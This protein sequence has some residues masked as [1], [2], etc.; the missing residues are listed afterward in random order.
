MNI[1]VGFPLILSLFAAQAGNPGSA[2][3]PHDGG[4]VPSSTAV[5]PLFNDAA[6]LEF[7]LSTDFRLLKRERGQVSN[8]R[9][10]EILLEGE[11][12]AIGLQVRTRG[13]FRL[14]RTTCGDMPPIRLNFPTSAVEGTVFEGQDKLKLVTHCRNNEQYEQNTLQEY[15]AYRIYNLLTDKSFQ[16]RLARITYVDTS[17]ED[18]PLTRYG[19]IIE[20]EDA[21]A[22]RLGGI[23]LEPPSVHPLDYDLHPMLLVT[24]FQ[25]MIGN[26]DFSMVQFHNIKLVRVGLDAH[27]PLPYDFD[28][29]GLVNARYAEP[30]ETLG[31]RNVRERLFRGFC[32]P[33][34][35]YEQ[36]IADM[37]AIRDDVFALIESQEGL[38]D[39]DRKDVREYIE[40]YYEILDSESRRNRRI[41]GA[42]RRI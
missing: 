22:E 37:M 35:D 15:L 27:Y 26:T 9:P 39:D 33:G 1:A 38:R 5:S 18:D 19:F 31:I 29:S 28:W 25:H 7:T 3:V 4:T 30:N 11:E 10:A 21:L 8:D 24:M 32:L 20:D 41:E 16:V 36:A 2:A 42:C 14:R 40:D 13:N 34:L 6:T 12:T 23:M 17:G